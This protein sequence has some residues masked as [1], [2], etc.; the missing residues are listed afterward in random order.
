MYIY[1]YI[2][3]II[4]HIYIYIYISY[5]WRPGPP[6]RPARRTG[7][8]GARTPPWE[9]PADFYL[10]VE[11]KHLL[12]TREL[13]NYEMLICVYFPCWNQH[14]QYVA[15]SRC[16]YSAWSSGRETSE[17]LQHMFVVAYFQNWDISDIKQQFVLYVCPP[18]QLQAR[19][20][21]EL[22]R[23]CGFLV[24]RWNI[25]PMKDK[26]ACNILRISIFK[27]KLKHLW[28]TR[29]LANLCCFLCAFS[30]LR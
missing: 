28:T 18:W 2:I 3:I 9:P 27:V 4:I 8:P 13:A 7:A 20:K 17:S 16:A 1:I 24:Q 11:I 26:R 30:T 6:S 15:S 29:E 25:T 12:K 23:C 10:T 14:P 19:D 22:A 5:L 21:R